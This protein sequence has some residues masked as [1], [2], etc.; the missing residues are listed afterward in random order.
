[1]AEF[2]K[3][4]RWKNYFKFEVNES[5]IQKL[6]EEIDYLHQFTHRVSQ[7]IINEK[8]S[9]SNGSFRINWSTEANLTA[10]LSNTLQDGQKILFRQE[11]YLFKPLEEKNILTIPVNA[12]LSEE[13]S[14]KIKELHKKY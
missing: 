4:L 6:I 13:I 3:V 8:I 12:K 14:T 9:I 10:L 5:E 1:L 2:F 7:D 11:N